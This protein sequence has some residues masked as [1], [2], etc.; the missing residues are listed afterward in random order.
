[1]P[2]QIGAP[3][4]PDALVA[5]DVVQEEHQDS[6]A[7]PHQIAARVALPSFATAQNASR[8]R[9]FIAC[10]LAAIRPSDSA[11]RARPD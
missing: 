10:R 1:V 2:R 11:R 8:K 4:H 7:Q 5:G 6:D 9:R 3:A